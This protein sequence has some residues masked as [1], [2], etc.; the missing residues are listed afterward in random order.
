MRSV[1]DNAVIAGLRYDYPTARSVGCLPNR[2]PYLMQGVSMNRHAR[3]AIGVV[4]RMEE[5][6]YKMS[7]IDSGTPNAFIA[8]GLVIRNANSMPSGWSK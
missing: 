5:M 4:S 3:W 1:H 6:V 7:V 8:S 2:L